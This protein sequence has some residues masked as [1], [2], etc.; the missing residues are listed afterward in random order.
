MRMMQLGVCGLVLALFT[1][2]AAAGE[3]QCRLGRVIDGDTVAARCGSTQSRI[4]LDCID[5]P[6][7]DQVPWGGQAREA[8]RDLLP[9][10]FVAR[11]HGEDQYGR[12]IATLFTRSGGRDVNRALVEQGRAVVYDRYCQ[13]ASYFDAEARAR[14]AE[15]G[16]WSQPGLQRRPWSYRNQQ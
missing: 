7:H 6:E 12:S 10:E 8:L 2:E 15:R 16:V 11:V 14:S 3:V 9:R 13:R 1:V 5:A 4:R